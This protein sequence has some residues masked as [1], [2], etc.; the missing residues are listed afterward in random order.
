MN[1]DKLGPVPRVDVV[2]EAFRQQ[3]P[4]WDPRNGEGARRRGGRYNPPG[5]FPTLYLCRTRA[6]AVAELR[7]EGERQAIGVDGLL[8]RTL[9][10]YRVQL[11][12]IVDLT[13]TE[14]LK[15]L[16]VTTDDLTSRDLMVTQEIGVAAHHLGCRGLI[17]PS[18]TGVDS[19]LVVFVQN[20][21]LG[22][23]EPS[24]AEVWTTMDALHDP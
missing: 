18:A 23:V 19:I 15:F 13:D 10:R 8:P 24:P 6:C 11:D 2:G 21:G 7:R 3:A 17:A 16:D 22:I 9:F 20:I 12:G 1:A 4:K 14:V 5:S